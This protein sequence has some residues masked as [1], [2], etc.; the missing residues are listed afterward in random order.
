[1]P[2]AKSYPYM[3]KRYLCKLKLTGT[4]HILIDMEN[5]SDASIKPLAPE[6]DLVFGDVKYVPPEATAGRMRRTFVEFFVRNGQ[7]L[8]TTQR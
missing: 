3:T 6:D 5:A 8:D 7:R 2:Q 4:G 1:M